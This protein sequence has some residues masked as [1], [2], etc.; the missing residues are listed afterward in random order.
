MKYED[1]TP[2]EKSRVRDSTCPLCGEKITKLD[3][4]QQI[5]MKYGRA[6]IYYNFHSNCLLQLRF[7]SQLGGVENEKAT[8]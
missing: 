3:D 6:L 5:K 2:Y 4:V 8:V 1:M 7:P